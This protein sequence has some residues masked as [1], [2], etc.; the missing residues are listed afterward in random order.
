MRF[1]T[2]MNQQP[3]KTFVNW[4]RLG[5]RNLTDKDYN[6]DSTFLFFFLQITRRIIFNYIND[7][8]DIK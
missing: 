2:I 4:I 5:T 6:R 7:V 3:F 1:A 8:H